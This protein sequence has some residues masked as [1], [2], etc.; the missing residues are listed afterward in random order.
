MLQK[1][2]NNERK[3]ILI[4]KEEK[5]Q[6][7]FSSVINLESIKKNDITYETSLNKNKQS[8]II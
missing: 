8:S 4:K 7:Y 3:K 1:Q 5:R 6:A 2:E